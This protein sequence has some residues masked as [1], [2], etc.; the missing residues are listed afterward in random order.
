NGYCDPETCRTKEFGKSVEPCEGKNLSNPTSMSREANHSTL[1][2]D[3]SQEAQATEALE[4]EM[5]QEM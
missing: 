4:E 2:A 5:E 3:T 1:Q